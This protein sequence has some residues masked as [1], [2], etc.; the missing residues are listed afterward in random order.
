MSDSAYK[1]L[2][3]SPKAFKTNST[4]GSMGADLSMIFLEPEIG[5]KVCTTTPFHTAF[6]GVKPPIKNVLPPYDDFKTSHHT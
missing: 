1:P 6:R 4:D 2:K 3:T 5:T